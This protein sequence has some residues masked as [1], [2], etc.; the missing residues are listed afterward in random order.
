MR[1]PTAAHAALLTTLVA[2]WVACAALHVKQLV[3]GQLAWVGVYVTAAPSPDAFPIVRGIWPGA[4]PEASGGLAAGDRTPRRRRGPAASVRSASRRAYAATDDGAP[5]TF[6]HLRRDGTAA[7]TTIALVPVAFRGGPAARGRDGPTGAL[8]L[9]RQPARFARAFCSTSPGPT[10]RSSS[11]GRCCRRTRGSWSV[12]ASCVMLPLVLRAVLIFP[13]EV[14]P[15]GGR[16]PWWP[17]LFAVFGPISSSWVYGVPF[18]PEV[19][20]RAVFAVNVAFIVTLLAVLTRNFRRAGPIGRRQLGG[21]C[22]ASTSAGTRARGRR[23]RGGR[24]R[25]LVAARGR[26]DRGDRHSALRA[27]R[28]RAE[29]LPR[30]RPSHHRRR[31]LLA[32]LGPA[33]GR[34]PHRGPAGGPGGEP[35]GC[36]RSAHGPARALGTVAAGMLPAQRSRRS[37]SACCSASGTR[38]A[39]ASTTCCTTS[40]SP[41]APRRC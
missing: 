19:G 11:A 1:R 27:D 8:V 10:G 15:P 7:E 34:G 28:D 6:R 3:H 25:A 40:P 12:A 38:S 23:R 20:F 4:A 18:P 14:A 37:S 32:A 13:A 36:R 2:L 33:A 31:R 29:Q 35:R 16:V 39:P 9:A 30:R 26:G 22:S 41:T 21:S 24:A 17:W 5:C